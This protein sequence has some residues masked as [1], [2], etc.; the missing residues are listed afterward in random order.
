[1]IFFPFWI[2]IFFF[3]HSS[4]DH[5]LFLRFSS[6]NFH[7]ILL[8]DYDLF[9]F[10]NLDLFFSTFQKIMILFYFFL[11]GF[12]ARLSTVTNAQYIYSPSTGLYVS[13]S[14]NLKGLR[15]NSPSEALLFR[16]W[17]SIEIDSLSCV[18]V[19]RSIKFLFHYFYEFSFQLGFDD[20]SVSIQEI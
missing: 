5:N 18:D 15:G 16:N 8:S 19:E 10:S 4:K 9:P 13:L 17:E 1:M 12:S 14:F 7:F 20:I 11:N 3:S 6:M 2:L